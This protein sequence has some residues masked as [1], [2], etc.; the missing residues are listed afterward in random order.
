[1]MLEPQ[2]KP[3]H[4]QAQGRAGRIDQDVVNRSVAR[5]DHALVDLIS[6]RVQRS[7]GES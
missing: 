5:G 2:P 4:A 7:Q 6:N 3:D 1:M